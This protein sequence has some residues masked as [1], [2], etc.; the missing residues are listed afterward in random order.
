MIGFPNWVDTRLVATNAGFPGRDYELMFDEH[1][2]YPA[3]PRPQAI[4]PKPAG[5]RRTGGASAALS[6]RLDGTVRIENADQGFLVFLC[7][8][9]RTL[10]EHHYRPGA[11]GTTVVCLIHGK[12]APP[13]SKH[14]RGLWVYVWCSCWC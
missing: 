4:H 2:G 6:A 5:H 13:H 12:K 10:N 3:L 11:K 7:L 1:L 8:P 14:A 9:E